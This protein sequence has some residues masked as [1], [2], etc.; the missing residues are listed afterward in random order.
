MQ[1]FFILSG[2]TN[3][4]LKLGLVYGLVVLLGFGSASF[5]QDKSKDPHFSFTDSTN[6][7]L[8]ASL[9]TKQKLIDYNKPIQ[10]EL[11]PLVRGFVQQYAAKQTE[12]YQKMK[13]W[14][15]RYFDLYDRILPQ[16]GIPKE[17]KYLSVIESYLNPGTISWAG[18]VG[19][20]QLMPDEADRFGLRRSEGID[21]RMDFIKS[22]HAACKLIK[23]L[24][25]TFEDWLLVIAAYNGG[26][27]RVKQCI[28]KAGGSKN[29]YDIQ[30]YLPEETRNH[31]KKYIATHYIFEGSGGWTTMTL[32]ETNAYLSKINLENTTAVNLTAEELNITDVVEVGG[33][34][35]SV[36]VS[37]SLLMD[38]D[39]FN[40]WN[41]GFD[42]A[43]ADGKKYQ[44]RLTKDR[45]K[46]FEA[47]KSQIL[48][49]SV[50]ALLNGNTETSTSSVK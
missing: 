39:Q 48:L 12:G 11:N 45:L 32:A 28:K 17:L 24:H 15:K 49:E 21:E 16:Y 36:I 19:P 22:T 35:L 41:P 50:R 1:R 26:V 25:S 13:V 47:R 33:R 29:F 4:K 38:I 7:S 6:A 3:N 18:A 23:E 31:V 44:L 10:A 14:G 5:T 27:G 20:W 40:R 2:Y 8:I 46:V 43:L 34:Y 30:Y 9:A 37:N 42:K